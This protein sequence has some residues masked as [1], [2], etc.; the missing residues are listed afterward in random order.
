MSHRHQCAD[1]I[2]VLGYP[3]CQYILSP[4]FVKLSHKRI[5]FPKIPSSFI[6]LSLF[7][8]EVLTERLKLFTYLLSN[9]LVK[10]EAACSG[11]QGTAT[12]DLMLPKLREV[13]KIF[14]IRVLGGRT[15]QSQ[16]INKWKQV[17]ETI[18]HFI[19]FICTSA[20]YMYF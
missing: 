17:S 4:C 11:W 19:N 1:E 12:R 7:A 6:C 15:D 20:V 16:S 9:V 13:R 2:G 18:E 5:Q 14:L 10:F 3:V 8:I